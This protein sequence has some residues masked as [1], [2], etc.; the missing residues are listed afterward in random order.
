MRP[1]KTVYSYIR[2]AGIS[3][4]ASSEL[5]IMLSVFNLMLKKWRIFPTE[6]LAREL[7]VDIN[8]QFALIIS[9]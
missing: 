7:E 3:V 5:F 9:A 6:N 4:R 8:I 2:Y 1:A